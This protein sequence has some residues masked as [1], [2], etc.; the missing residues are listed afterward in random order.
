MNLTISFPGITLEP[1]VV[2]TSPF[3]VIFPARI[4]SSASLLEQT[5][6]KEINLFKRTPSVLLIPGVV[7]TSGLGFPFLKELLFLGV[8]PPVSVLLVWLVGR[9]FG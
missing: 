4:C 6:L 7:L 5:P 1:K 9:F 3:T 8:N 2:T